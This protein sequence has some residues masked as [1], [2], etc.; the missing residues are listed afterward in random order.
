VPRLGLRDVVVAALVYAVATVAITWP[1]FRHPGTTVL[2][3][4]SL[5][6]PAIVPIQRDVNLTMWI[7]AWDVHALGTAPGRL[8]D[9]N[10]F[11]PAPASLARS[12]HMLGNVPL[13][14]PVWL[15]TGNPVLAHQATLFASFVLSG[16]AM[17]AWAFRWTRDRMAAL[18]AGLAFAV[19]PVRLWQM[20]NLQ[21][22]STQYLPLVL[23]A[24][25]ALLA[26]E[27]RAG[28]TA[29]LAAALV[30]SVGCSYYVGYAA[31]VAAAVYAGVRVV[32]A[33]A[34]HAI[35]PLVVAAALAVAVVLPLSLPYLRLQRAG[36]LPAYD[37]PAQTSLALL[38]MLKHG[39]AGLSSFFVW[40]RRDGIPQFLGWTVLALAGVA[41]LRPD[42]P[43][44]ALAALLATGVVLSLGPFAL[45]P[46]GH[47]RVPLPY[48][49]LQTIVPG[50]SAMRAPQRMGVIATLAATALAG[51]GLARLRAALA[52]RGRQRAATAVAIGVAALVLLEAHVSGLDVR[53]MRTGDAVP[54]A[55]RWLVAHGDGGALLELPLRRADLQRESL[56]MYYSTFHW[57]PIANGYSSYPPPSWI[58]LAD[59]AASL[60]SAEAVDAVL[61]PGERWVLFH[62]DGV[63]ADEAP[64]WNAALSA[65][66]R[67]VEDFGDAV[68]YERAR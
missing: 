6:G 45:V 67:R 53:G 41:V 30:L 32:G 22:V 26:R 50:F 47:G 61:A 19:A 23:L 62:R 27:A 52:A 68:L 48:R 28:A 10:A 39:V 4:R 24:I 40:P 44:G 66:L 42:A 2:E 38:G 65:R 1:L 7:L 13:F 58:A 55:Y 20:G 5:Y 36:L 59:A 9:A 15:A 29:L 17:A 16:L 56:Y 46:G 11:W 31:L 54:A 33:R 64:R 34:W 14:G 35:P 8:F 3:T 37:A 25:D 12:E 60:P 21:V 18:V 49:L 63:S 43:R 51:L 57:L